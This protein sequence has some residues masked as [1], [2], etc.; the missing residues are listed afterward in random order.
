M[1][2]DWLPF[3]LGVGAGVVAGIVLVVLPGRVKGLEGD[4]PGRPAMLGWM[5]LGLGA[6]TVVLSLLVTSKFGS[7]LIPWVLAFGAAALT[8]AV[9]AIVKR[10]RKWATWV[11]LVLGVVPALFWALFV[12]GFA[13]GGPSQQ[14]Y[15]DAAAQLAKNN[16]FTALFP[17]DEKPRLGEGAEAQESDGGIY[18]NYGHFEVLERPASGATEQEL[19]VRVS[20]GATPL[21]NMG[22]SVE[23]GGNV[24]TLTVNGQIAAANEYSYA[25]PLGDPKGE[26]RDAVVL[27][28]EKD[29]VDVRMMSGTPGAGDKLS[30]E[31]LADIAESMRPL[32]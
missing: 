26:K 19:I 10:E 30:L 29:G 1:A 14:E 21:G 3:L 6:T 31:A 24:A 25:F 12:L 20:D 9:G 15:V 11:G 16:G 7:A 32:E 27:V 2:A 18:M 13:L 8:V 17:R 23:P 5:S 4:N 22:V 28:F